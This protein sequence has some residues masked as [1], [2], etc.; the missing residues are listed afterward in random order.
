MVQFG[1]IVGCSSTEQ[2][3]LI[4]TCHSG[5]AYDIRMQVFL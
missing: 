1:S 2:N 4:M 5:S 3:M